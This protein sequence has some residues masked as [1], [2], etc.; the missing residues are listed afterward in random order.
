[1]PYVADNSD[2]SIL[3]LLDGFKLHNNVLSANELH[4]DHNIWLLKEESNLSH[5][6]QGYDQLTAK[7]DKKNAVKSLYDQCRVQKWRSNWVN[8]DQYDL[9]FTALRIV[10]QCKSETW[11]SLFWLVNLDPITQMSFKDWCKKIGPY[12][13]A[14]EVYAE[15]NVDLMPQ[16]LFNL[17]PS[18]WHGMQPANR[19]VVTTIMGSH[20]W[21]FTPDCIK[22][23]H[24]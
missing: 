15:E 14:G 21:R 1:M 4:S 18:F 12:L 23:I 24:F 22:Q 20:G 16:Q 10:H 8:I 11:I 7:S 17:L 5:L 6:N 2:W 9:I 3:E 13:R 19:R